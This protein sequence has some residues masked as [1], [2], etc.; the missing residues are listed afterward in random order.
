MLEMPVS[1]DDHYKQQPQCSEV[2]W[3]FGAMGYLPRKA[4]NK[5]WNQPR[6]KKFVVVKKDKKELEI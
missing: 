5:D 2:N 1:W 4:A 3:D 6:R